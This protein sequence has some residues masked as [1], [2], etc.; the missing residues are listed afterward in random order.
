MNARELAQ[1]A[2]EYQKNNPDYQIGGAIY[3][4]IDRL[5]RDEKI[6]I[7]NTDERSRQALVRNL[8]TGKDR[9]GEPR[10]ERE[11]KQDVQNLEN[12][13]YSEIDASVI[14]IKTGR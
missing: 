1:R 7:I 2:I 11:Q 14:K 8:T 13:V 4:I 10:T 9:K 12:A 5:T 6:E 3:Q